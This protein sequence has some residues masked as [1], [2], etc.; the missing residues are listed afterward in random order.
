MVLLGM[1][2]FTT[3]QI[4]YEIKRVIDKGIDLCTDWTGSTIPGVSITNSYTPT[5]MTGRINQHSGNMHSYV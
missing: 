3:I 5:F 2:D 4:P 1:V